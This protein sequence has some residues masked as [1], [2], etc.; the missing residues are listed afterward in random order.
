MKTNINQI[1]FFAQ[2]V[3]ERAKGARVSGIASR[4]IYLQPENDLTLYLSLEEFPGP[5][6]LNLEEGSTRVEKIKAGCSARF[7]SGEIYFPDENIKISHNGCKIWNSPQV[8]YGKG[9]YPQ[10]LDTVLSLAKN[11]ASEN[12]YLPLL[13]E[14]PDQI[15]GVAVIGER[16][17]NLQNALKTGVSE[18]ITAGSIKL[19]G[20]GPGLTPLGDDFLLGVLLTFNRWGHIFSPVLPEIQKGVSPAQS[21]VE[22]S[23]HPNKLIKDL[24]QIILENSRLKT[25]QISASLLACAVEGAADERLLKVL[26]GFFSGVD[27]TQNEIKNL[28]RWGSSSGITVL[29]GMISVLRTKDTVSSEETV[30]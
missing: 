16:I 19:L 9:L 29:A 2:Q 28:L 27:I 8:E 17:Q 1:G 22:W 6:T 12:P 15:P 23:S 24:N 25:T 21:I 13:F 18:K 11:I 20:L 7:K 30:S 3:L 14:N 4:G 26:D 5:L 10:G